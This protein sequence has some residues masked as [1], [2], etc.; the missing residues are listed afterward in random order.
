MNSRPL[1]PRWNFALTVLLACTS[2]F[3]LGRFINR[4]AG[5]TAFWYDESVQYWISRGLDA[6]GPPVQ[7]PGGLADVMKHNGLANLDPGGFSVILHYWL[8]VARDPMWQRI[9]PLVIFA[10]GLLSLGW[11]GWRWRRSAPFA[12]FSALVPAAFPMLLDYAN[13]V[14]AYSMEFTGVFVGCLLLDLFLEKPGRSLSFVGGLAL[15]VFLTSRYSFVFVAVAIS[16]VWLFSIIRL[17]ESWSRRSSHLVLFLVPLGLAGLAVVFLG[18]VPQYHARIAYDG[19]SMVGYLNPYKLGVLPWGDWLKLL[20]GNLFSPVALPT[21]VIPLVALLV[22]RGKP[23]SREAGSPWHRSRQFYI[24]PLATLAFTAALW[25]WHPW[26]VHTKWS[27]YLQALSAVMIVRITADVLDAVLPTA[28]R[29]K[30]FP[31]VGQNHLALERAL[32]AL[33]IGVF[34]ICLVMHRRV[35]KFD[36]VK[37]LTYLDR[38]KPKRGTVSVEPHSYPTLRYFYD[39]GPFRGRAFY[40]RAFRLPHWHGAAPLIGEKS[41]FVISGKYS[42]HLRS[43]YPEVTFVFDPALPR[44]LVRVQSISPPTS[45][46]SSEATARTTPAPAPAP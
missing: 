28:G 39:E 25:K 40:P 37:T 41:L 45:S 10:T 18:F 16:A 1:H 42:E 9:L 38:H 3:A 23:G 33:A 21:T 43:T 15:G 7:T 13:E 5:S 22:W 27:S 24:L 44:H 26:A 35:N 36:L 31:M 29:W 17:P 8:M 11:L 34:C 20:A 14:R 19:G 12:L 4:A 30:G 6:F 2:A 46:P 32:L